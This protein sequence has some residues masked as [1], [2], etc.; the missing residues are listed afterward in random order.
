MLPQY[1]DNT[2]ILTFTG[3]VWGIKQLTWII[4]KFK[5]SHKVYVSDL[6]SMGVSIAFIDQFVNTRSECVFFAAF[7]PTGKCLQ[8]SHPVEQS[9]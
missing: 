4:D 6:S 3:F 9:V 1:T 2:L 8:R 7:L 5:I